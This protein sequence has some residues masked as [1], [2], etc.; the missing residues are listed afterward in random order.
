MKTSALLSVLS[1]SI[2]SFVAG[3]SRSAEACTRY[4]ATN[5]HVASS[6]V[7]ASSILVTTEDDFAVSGLAAVEVAGYPDI[8]PVGDFWREIGVVGLPAPNIG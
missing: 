8:A 6:S 3:Q 7:T 5:A 1:I 4:P 2:L